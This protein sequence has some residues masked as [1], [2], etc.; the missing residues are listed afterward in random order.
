M[1]KKPS[2]IMTVD[3]EE[4][5]HGLDIHNSLAKTN[6]NHFETG[7]KILVD[8]FSKYNISST[9]FFV[10]ETALRYPDIVKYVY[11][12]GHSIGS[13]SMYHKHI[14]ELT[15]QEFHSDIIRN[16]SILE[17]IISHPVYSFRAPWFS[18]KYAN[19]PAKS[20]LSD[21]GYH[22][23]SSET[24]N[25]STGNHGLKSIPISMLSA[26][27]LTFPAGGGYFRIL[28]H[29]FIDSAL[30][31][32]LNHNRSMVVFTHPY[33]LVSNHPDFPVRTMK[34]FKRM[35]RLTSS[36]SRFEKIISNYKFTSIEKSS[37]WA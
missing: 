27:N 24:G 37:S 34:G 29:S 36:A 25:V 8:I 7:I 6:A 4:W 15:E 16:K 3:A 26:L 5:F 18:L 32:Y 20:I 2:H 28:P 14:S 22:F 35:L 10:G 21:S 17:D 33:D 13:H 23:D 9:F 1:E 30:K 12:S 19:F 31:R 11:D